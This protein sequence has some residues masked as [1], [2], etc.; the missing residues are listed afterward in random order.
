M[1]WFL[2]SFS[3]YLIFNYLGLIFVVDFIHQSVDPSQC[4]AILYCGAIS[5]TPCVFL[6]GNCLSYR[7]CEVPT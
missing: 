3:K 2:F 5:L 6:S 4:C 7:I 1:I